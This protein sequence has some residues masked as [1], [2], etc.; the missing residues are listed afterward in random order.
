MSREAREL[1]QAERK[2]AEAWGLVT[3]RRAEHDQARAEQEGWI[4]QVG[5]MVNDGELEPD[6][7]A[8]AG[9]TLESRRLVSAMALANAERRVPPARTEVLHAR[10]RLLTSRVDALDRV[11]TA[12][13]V[14]TDRLLAQLGEYEGCE[15][16]A[17]VP[18]RLPP[19]V[20]AEPREFRVPLTAVVETERDRLAAVAAG[21]QRVLAAS[22]VA[23][24]ERLV[25]KPM[26]ETSEVEVAALVGDWPA[27][28]PHGG[29]V[30]VQLR[31]PPAPAPR[32]PLREFPTG[33]GPSAAGGN[34]VGLAAG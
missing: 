17:V 34:L 14:Q 1:E 29:R 15:F 18:P 19:G 4:S 28:L 31:T 7:A 12:R 9:A 33:A 20:Y 27:L 22:D 11:V 13:R 6:E 8:R 16:A 3:R 25:G 26:L 24:T 21:W 2:L 32:S 23:G 5:R 30:A 10:V